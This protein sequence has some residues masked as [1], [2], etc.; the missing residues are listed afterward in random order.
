VPDQ[1]E[2]VLVPHSISK[3]EPVPLRALLVFPVLIS[4]TNYVLLALL[5][6]SK[7]A[8]QPLFL[9]TPIEYGGL[10]LSPP[11]VSVATHIHRYLFFLIVS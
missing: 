2:L 8:L 11:T 3:E 10:G 4:I 7:A 5:E 1:G 6:I 9:S